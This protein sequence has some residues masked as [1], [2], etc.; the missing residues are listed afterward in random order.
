MTSNILFANATPMRVAHLI[1]K[2][3]CTNSYELATFPWDQAG[4]NTLNH[5]CGTFMEYVAHSDM[6]S[7]SLKFLTIMHCFKSISLHIGTC[8]RMHL[9]CSKW[10]LKNTVDI[11][12]HQNKNAPT[13]GSRPYFDNST[14]KFTNTLAMQHRHLLH[15]E[16]YCWLA[17]C[18][19]A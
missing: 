18:F 9:R 3:I 6:A 15:H 7:P 11:W 17:M 13:K 14:P 4:I 12:N 16:C 8:H 1:C 2:S 19:G 5:S 10:F